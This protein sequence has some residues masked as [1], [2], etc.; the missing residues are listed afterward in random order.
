M[1]PPVPQ[2]LIASRVD[3]RA[4]YRKNSKPIAAVDAYPKPIAVPPDAGSSAAT[5]TVARIMTR[6][7]ST[8]DP[9]GGVP[10]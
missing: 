7:R 5:A 2:A 1:Q 10:A 8:P 3:N 6:N 4:P 9:G